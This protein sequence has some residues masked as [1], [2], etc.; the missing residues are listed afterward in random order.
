MIQNCLINFYENDNSSKGTFPQFYS[1]ARECAHLLPLKA[2]FLKSWIKK[3]IIKI[4]NKEN[5]RSDFT[6]KLSR[7]LR[8]SSASAQ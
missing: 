4:A 2:F 1:A 6:L 7:P 3:E 5:F 8:Y